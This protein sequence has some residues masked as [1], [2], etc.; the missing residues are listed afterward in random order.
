MNRT[1]YRLL[2]RAKIHRATVTAA[3]PDYIGSIA[4][5]GDLMERVDLWPG[6]QVHV[7]DVDNGERFV[8]YAVPAP[9]GSGAVIVNGAAAHRVR[10]G[11]RVIVAAFVLAAEPV[12]PRMILVDEENR[13][14]RELG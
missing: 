11:D 7:W 6:E 1:Q 4:I 12:T 2:C 5:D 13:F 9:R 14:V 8:T 3:D 10:V